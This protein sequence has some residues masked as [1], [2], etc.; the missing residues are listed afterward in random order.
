MGVA[1]KIMDTTTAA[2]PKQVGRVLIDRG[3]ITEAQIQQALAEQKKSGHHKLLGETI[4]ELGFCTE[5][6]VVEALAEAYGMPYVKL[7]PKLSD[8]RVLSALPREFIEKQCVLPLFKVDDVLTVAV[9]EPANVFLI[10]EIGEIAKC[11][12]QFVAATARDIHASL[13]L[14]QTNTKGLDF[15]ELLE[16]VSES[17]DT[18]EEPSLDIANLADAADG[19][20]VIKLANYI[21]YNAVRD[22]ASDIHIE[23]DDNQ[24]RVR[25]RIDGHLIEKLN[26]PVQMAAALISRLKIMAS[27]DISERRLP[28]DGAIHVRI[29][30]RPVDLRVS[31]LPN[32]HGEKIVLRIIDNRNAMVS[33]A[34][35]GFDMETLEKFQRQVKQP[36]GLMLVTGPTGSGKS[37]TLYAALAELNSPTINICTVEDPIEF[38]VPGINQ[39]QVNEKIG[40]TFPGTLRSLLRQDPDVIMIGEIRDAETAKIAVQSALTG[41]MVFSTLHTNDA[42]GAVTRLYNVGVEPYLISASLSGVLAQRLVRKLCSSCSEEAIPPSNILR[43]AERLGQ[44]VDRMFVGVGCS[45]CRK[46]GYSGRI[47]LYEMMTPDD[48]M[49]DAITASA[50]LNAL[51]GHA[52]RMG[53][54]SLVEDGFEKIR[55]GITTAEEVIRVTAT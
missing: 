39:F 35:L 43:A 45:K 13:A 27:L 42:P 26:P 51:R 5:D 32:R 28:Q 16:D 54:R 11:A 44:T 49:R 3:L 29:E 46:S 14:H 53:M 24:L 21:I 12:V 37:T 22:G 18:V 47:G 6:Q 25:Y 4:I 31:I 40:F 2:P 52:K 19:S 36:H 50:T 38:N 7:N 30:G 48:E 8:P 55:Q 41:H 23:P 10:E 9:H 17:I 20:P 15:E 33:L 34:Q 1:E